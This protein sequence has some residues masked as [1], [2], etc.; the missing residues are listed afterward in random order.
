MFIDFFKKNALFK[1]SMLACLGG[2]ASIVGD[3]LIAIGFAAFWMNPLAGLGLI[4][5]GIGVNL[6]AGWLKEKSN[7]EYNKVLMY[8][9]AGSPL[10]WV[11]DPS[12]YVYAGLES[13]RIPGATAT[14]YGIINKGMLVE[15][16][17]ADELERRCTK[18]LKIRCSEPKAAADIICSKFGETQFQIHDDMLDIVFDVNR[19]ATVNKLLV[20]SGIWVSELGINIMS[21]EDY[22]LT[23]MGSMDVGRGV[24]QYA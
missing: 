3:T 14:V 8:L 24:G 7:G 22:F 5:L 18:S 2:L 12:G 16:I 23:R 19:S 21:Y 6:F 20:D 11:I 17:T 10:V 15:E 1:M 4:A 13:N 9:Y